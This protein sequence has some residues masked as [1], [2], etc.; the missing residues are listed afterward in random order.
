MKKTLLALPWGLI[1]GALIGWYLVGILS[2]ASV[3]LQ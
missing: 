2:S 3:A 1:P